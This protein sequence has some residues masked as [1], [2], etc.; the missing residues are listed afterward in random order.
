MLLFDVSMSELNKIS[1]SSA[2]SEAGS[3]TPTSADNSAERLSVTEQPALVGDLS[4]AEVGTVIPLDKLQ[5]K[6]EAKPEESE[7]S[8]VQREEERA[9]RDAEKKLKEEEAARKMVVFDELKEISKLRG[10]FEVSVIERV[11][12]GLRCDY[13]GFRIFLPASHLKAKSTATEAEM[14]ELIGKNLLVHVHDVQED[15]SGFRS[16]II[17]RKAIAREEAW[18]QI[19]VGQVYDGFITGVS[20]FG[21]FVNIGPMEGLCHVSRLSKVRIDDP[22]KLFKKGDKLRVTVTD[23]NSDKKKLALSH[24]EH[25]ENPWQGIEEKYC[26]GTRVT[27]TVKR[28]TEFGAYVEVEPRIEGLIRLPEL[29]WTRRIN[30]PSEV[31][32][33]GQSIECEIIS[34][35]ESKHQMALSY[36]SCIPNPWETLPE[37]L[38][39]GADA[40][41]TVV[42]ATPKGAVVRV[43]GEFDGFIPRSR[44][45]N[46]AKFK[47][48]QLSAGDSF[49][50]AVIDLDAERHSLIL[51]MKADDGT[52][53]GGS[54]VNDSDSSDHSFAPKGVPAKHTPSS[55]SLGDM[56]SD[57]DKTRLH[58]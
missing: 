51:A 39:I 57:T 30:H 50:V 52:I 32:E 9:R 31:L 53:A 11:R 7:E 5:P 26:A 14:Q 16:V 27:G 22:T 44:F 34:V 55:V 38:T 1:D 45:L 28:L 49:P 23:I 10:R 36:R 42:A 6:T 4:N 19:Q 47:K 29:S 43:F 54:K 56:L 20:N 40:T 58:K 48:V 35:S 46:A 15:D 8:R 13:K 2:P 25:E 41:G 17:S 24:R 37:G 3:E 18:T 12:G 33:A 21:V